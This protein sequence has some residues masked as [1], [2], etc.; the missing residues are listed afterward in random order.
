MAV[1][2]LAGVIL[3]TSSCRHHDSGAGT[4]DSQQEDVSIQSIELVPDSVSLA[5]EQSLRL[6]AMGYFSDGSSRD[7]TEDALWDSLNESVATVSNTAGDQGMVVG[8]SPGQTTIRASCEGVSGQAILTVTR[9]NQFPMESTARIIFLHRSTGYRIL[10]G[11]VA[12][13]FQTYNTRNG[14]GYVF[15]DRPF[16]N[17]DPRGRNDNYPYDYWNAWVDHYGDQPLW[18]EP[19]LEVLTR[20]YDVVVWKHCYPVSD[21]LPDTGTGDI[22]SDIKRVENYKLQYEALKIKMRQFPQTRFVVWTG[23]AR[24]QTKTTREQAERAR[25]F[26][27][28][29]KT[30]WDEPGDNIFIW[31]FFELETDGGLYLHDEYATSPIDSHPNAEFS[32][33]VAPFLCNRIIC[34][35]EGRGD[36]TSLDG[37]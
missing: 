31:D 13:I 37:T 8:V 7:I 4:D 28:W 24:V 26:F 25:A 22:S 2:L 9:V 33:T 20:E 5:C 17:S 32:S 14:T 10:A 34:V 19:T 23:A 30:V 1:L 16:P 12:G 18:N 21:V 3:L 36:S 35:I 6:Q 29:V 15:E 11:G 27:D